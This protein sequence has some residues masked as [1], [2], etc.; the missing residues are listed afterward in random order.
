MHLHKLISIYLDK[1][2]IYIS[3]F[4]VKISCALIFSVDSNKLNAIP[5]LTSK[6]YKS[7]DEGKRYICNFLDLSTAADTVNHYL[8]LE[9]YIYYKL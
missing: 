6:V 1:Y 3:I 4:C 9:I 2:F 7:V 5:E 8:I